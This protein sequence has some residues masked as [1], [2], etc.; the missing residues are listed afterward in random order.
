M[1]EIEMGVERRMREE[2]ER[3]AQLREERERAT[4]AREERE[5]AAQAAATPRRGGPPAPT[6]TNTTPA[7]EQG[8]KLHQVMQNLWQDTEM[9]VAQAYRSTKRP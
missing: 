8:K 2:R 7:S 5:R 3:S 9:S 1:R 6:G 4:Q